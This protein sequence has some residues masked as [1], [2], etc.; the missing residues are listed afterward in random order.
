M[1]AV[2]I[3]I[4][5]L[6]CLGCSSIRILFWDF[7]WAW[8]SLG[9]V[10][11][12]RIGYVLDLV[13]LS[14]ILE[15]SLQGLMF[16]ALRRDPHGSYSLFYGNDYLPFIYLLC[17]AGCLDGIILSPFAI[18]QWYLWLLRFRLEECMSCIHMPTMRTCFCTYTYE[19]NKLVGIHYYL[20]FIS[21]ICLEW[22]FQKTLLSCIYNGPLFWNASFVDEAQ[23]LVCLN[24]T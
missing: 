11:Q 13:W 21:N 1:N 8:H 20:F 7:G 5:V 4:N 12:S 22:S 23:R 3:I 9:S 2:T 6:V 16:F 24:L 19:W 18:H 14:W 10:T 17:K 15:A